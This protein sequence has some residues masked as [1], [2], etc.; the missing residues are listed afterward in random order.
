MKE[1]DT[2]L[3]LM[4]EITEDDIVKLT[5][6]KIKRIS[7]YNS[8]KTDELIAELENEL[9]QV[10]YDLAHLTEFTIK[11]FE[12][13][14]IT[15]GKGRE[16]KT[17]IISIETIESKDVIEN[18][19]KL[20]VDFENGFIGMNNKLGEF[21][22]DCSDIDDV[23]GFRQDGNFIVNR[24]GDKVFMGENLLH[25]G[26]WKKD[27]DRTVYHLIYLD[28]N[29]GNTYAKRF[30]VNA[31]TRDRAYNLMTEHKYS[32]VLYFS[33]NPNGETET[34]KISLTPGSKARIKVFDFDFGSL[35]IKG[36]G[37]L[38]NI[39]T[40]YPVRK[41]NFIE[42]GKSS[43]G[44][45]KI[46][47]DKITGKIN[48]NELG[49]F[50]G[51]FDTDDKIIVFYKSGAYEVKEVNFVVSL[52]MNSIVAVNKLS[53]TKVV[54]VIYYEG[55]KQWTM[56][57]R[58]VVDTKQIDE[59]YLFI[60]DHKD[61]K[62]YYV[63]MDQNPVVNFTYNHGGSDVEKELQIADFVAVKGWKALGNKLGEFKIKSLEI[64]DVAEEQSG[65]DDEIDDEG[66]ESE[67]MEQSILDSF[68]E[69]ENE[70]EDKNDNSDDDSDDILHVGDSIEF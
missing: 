42:K 56:V 23:I 45:Q 68:A 28:G 8:F 69:D 41:V 44:K 40:K 57:K 19:A 54:N 13:L 30:Q 20:Y 34:V 63:T 26:I 5:E 33:V 25:A 58:F 15:Y 65:A 1:G 21:I 22:C 50:I 24:I 17:E 31:I 66:N 49:E 14:K 64:V 61:S 27:D 52:D 16:R 35:S 9:K 36:R 48:K 53:E 32:K 6:I 2:R 67:V 7:K 59:K 47:Y 4:R 3:K 29:S 39:V 51:E 62:L 38:G 46:W 18:N 70:A 60:S 43:L 10:N 55:D 12:H 11:Y 37:S